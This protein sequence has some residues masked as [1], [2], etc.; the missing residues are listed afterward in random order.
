MLT[1][2]GKTLVVLH[3]RFVPKMIIKVGGSYNLN[4]FWFRA[5]QWNVLVVASMKKI[6]VGPESP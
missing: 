3:I 1:N 2:E 4:D 6:L 5:L